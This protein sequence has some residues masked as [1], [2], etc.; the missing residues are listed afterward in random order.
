MDY[1]I[2]QDRGGITDN[3]ILNLIHD[4][5]LEHSKQGMS[6]TCSNYSIDHVHKLLSDSIILYAV[7]ESGSLLGMTAFH[8][9]SD[10][11]YYG[12]ITCISP[13][14][15]GIGIGTALYKCRKKFD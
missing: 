9:V 1:R 7:S 13:V 3:D 15:K 12:D 5:F 14:A 2:T 6:F 8:E 10:G 4:S 11:K